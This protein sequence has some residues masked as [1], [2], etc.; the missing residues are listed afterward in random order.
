MDRDVEFWERS[1]V[2]HDRAEKGQFDVGIE[3]STFVVEQS[4][5]VPIPNAKC[6]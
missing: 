3:H 6:S 5:I 1:Q 4:V 2:E